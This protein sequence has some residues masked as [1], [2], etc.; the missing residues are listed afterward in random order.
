M[1][2]LNNTATHFNNMASCLMTVR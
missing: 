1:T 2:I